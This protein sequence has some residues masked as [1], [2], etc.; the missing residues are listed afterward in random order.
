MQTDRK[1]VAGSPTSNTPLSPSPLCL[2]FLISSHSNFPSPPSIY[3][4]TPS[5]QNFS[6]HAA[7]SSGSVA[8]LCLAAITTGFLFSIKGQSITWGFCLQ[9]SQQGE[10][11]LTYLLWITWRLLGARGLG[12]WF[13]M[14]LL[15]ASCEKVR[16]PYGEHFKRPLVTDEPVMFASHTCTSTRSLTLYLRLC[17]GSSS[18]Y[19]L[20]TAHT[21]THTHTRALA[22]SVS[23]GNGNWASLSWC[24][25]R[26]WV[27]PHVQQQTLK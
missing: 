23:H 16:C 20:T 2:F 17:L 27:S 4:S 14:Q 6:P 19:F 5:I 26:V 9:V 25:V 21:H 11:H 15:L 12:D 22:L 1:V 24:Q 3:P 10:C 13:I 7:L 18:L 8:S